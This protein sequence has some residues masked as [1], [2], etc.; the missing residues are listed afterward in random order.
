MKKIQVTDNP[1]EMAS[2]GSSLFNKYKLFTKQ[3]LK[4]VKETIS[5]FMPNAGSVAI[6]RG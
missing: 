4:A 6:V 3:Q 2:I 5:H 1:K